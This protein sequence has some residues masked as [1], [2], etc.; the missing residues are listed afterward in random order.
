MFKR[1][2]RNNEIRLRSKMTFFF[3]ESNSNGLNSNR[4]KSVCRMK[5]Q[6]VFCFI[7]NILISTNISKSVERTK[8]RWLIDR[9]FS[10]S[11]CTLCL[12]ISNGIFYSSVHYCISGHRLSCLFFLNIFLLFLCR[13]EM[14]F[15]V[16]FYRFISWI[17]FFSMT[18]RTKMLI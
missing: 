10:R 1:T 16:N 17:V 9:P 14:V 13:N 2:R 18:K 5:C 12:S 15:V 3:I 4:K 7:W 6:S 8:Q 11:S